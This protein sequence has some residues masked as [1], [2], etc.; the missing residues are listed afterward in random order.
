MISTCQP[1]HQCLSTAGSL[2]SQV[3]DQ[4]LLSRE[5][6]P[7]QPRDQSVSATLSESVIRLISNCLQVEECLLSR[8]NC[9]SHPVDLRLLSPAMN[10]YSAS[11]S[12]PVSRLRSTWQPLD[13]HLIS[14]AIIIYSAARSSPQPLDLCLLSPA[15]SAYSAVRGAPDRHLR[16]TVSHFISDYQSLD[17]HLSTTLRAPVSRLISA[18]QRV[19]QHLSAA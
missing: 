3:C 19:D 13:Q 14:H 7:P 12:V 16:S 18:C 1:L 10:A 4:R 17:Q 6:A 5:S 8:A 15:I 2:P 9:I 11:R